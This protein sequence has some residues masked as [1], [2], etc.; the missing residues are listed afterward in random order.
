M[1]LWGGRRVVA[2]AGGVG[3]ARLVDGLARLLPADRLTIIV[4]TGDDF[5]LLG[6]SI[7][8]D[9]DTVLYTLAGVADPARGWGIEG[10]TF[11]CLEAL[12]RLGDPGWFQIGDRD[13][14][15]HLIR[16]QLLRAGM[17]LTQVSSE[18]GRRLKVLPR[19]L[20]MSD[21]LLRTW[22]LTQEEG[23]LP[24]QEYFVRYR[25]EPRVTGFRFEGEEAAQPSPEA[26]G[27]LETADLVIICPS[28]PLVSI[29]PILRLPGNRARLASLPCVAVSP[30]VG[31]AA[32]KGPLSK[33]LLELGR[34][35]N[36]LEIAR[37]YQGLVR[38][39]VLDQVDAELSS[40]VEV[41]GMRAAA[42]PTMMIE[43]SRRLRVAEQV[44]EFAWTIL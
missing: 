31:G 14:A 23:P 35:S 16:T 20:P 27:A 12:R 6:L 8:P 3:G 37:H 34:A 40:Q 30:I 41:L 17:T 44:L 11:H 7:S 29:D 38:G 18:L 32:I 19:V 24:F 13:L 22:V 42:F 28:N 1:D 4:N 15:T 9:L 36:A 2:L 21:D 5:E 25:C 33:M 26:L 43:A 39:F 10:D